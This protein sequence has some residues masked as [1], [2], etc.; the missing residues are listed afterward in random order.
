M[1]DR[2]V[3]RYNVQD[4]DLFGYMYDEPTPK[5]KSSK[6]KEEPSKVTEKTSKR[7]NSSKAPSRAIVD[8]KSGKP[9]RAP[10]RGSK[11]R[12]ALKVT[13]VS[14]LALVLV[15]GGGIG[16]A[17]Y[18]LQSRMDVGQVDDLLGTNRPKVPTSTVAPSDP[19][20]P[21]SGRAINIL[22]MGTDSLE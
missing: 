16:G 15:A 11:T 14:L 8:D 9:L 2:S 1:D 13:L 12:R 18:Y 6:A 4:D 22:V 17:L 20:D 5:K 21:Y 3:T 19:K 7:P 10:H